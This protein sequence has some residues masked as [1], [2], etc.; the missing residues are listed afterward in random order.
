MLHKLVKLVL[1]LLHL[2]SLNNRKYYAR[3]IY[4]RLIFLNNL[5]IKMLFVNVINVCFYLLHKI[6]VYA[7]KDVHSYFSQQ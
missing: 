3:V 5:Q 7:S 4:M 1:Y 6:N 2:R